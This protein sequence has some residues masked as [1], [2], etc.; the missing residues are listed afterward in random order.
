MP[1]PLQ[2]GDGRGKCVFKDIKSKTTFPR[3][4]TENVQVSHNDTYVQKMVQNLVATI[5][6]ISLHKL[7]NH[8]PVVSFLKKSNDRK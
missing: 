3:G 1:K 5:V 8:L 6:R 7:C 2:T 4:L